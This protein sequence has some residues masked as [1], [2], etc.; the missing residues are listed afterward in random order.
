[1][2]GLYFYGVLVNSIRLG[3]AQTFPDP[4]AP[5]INSIWEWNPVLSLAAIF[6]PTGIMVT[7]FFVL[8]T[9]L[10]TKRGYTW[11]SGYKF[12]R[13][14]RGFDILPDGT[15][16]T[17]GWMREKQMDLLLDRGKVHEISGTILGKSRRMKTMII[18]THSM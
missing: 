12:E 18:L 1:M 16:G 11:F 10:I 14:P 15:H 6:T 4:G 13:D 17:S 8:M 3:I 9:C 7:L 2:I 5:P